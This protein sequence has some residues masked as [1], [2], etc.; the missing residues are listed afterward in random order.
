MNFKL[1]TIAGSLLLACAVSAHAS[2]N[3]TPIIETQV[4]GSGP[5]VILIPGLMSDARV[6][7]ETATQLES[8]Y[9]VHRIS[10]AGFGQTPLNTELRNSFSEPVSN[11]LHQYIEQNTG[12]NTAVVGHSLGAFLGYQ[13]ALQGNEQVS[14]A[15][16][17]DGVPFF[18]ALVTMTPGMTAEQAQPHA[19]QML[20][21]YQQLSVEMM[22]QQTQMG[23]DRQTQSSQGQE[24]IM[25]MAE[26]SDPKTVGRAM[27]E[28]MI[29]D[30]R[31]ELPHLQTPVLQMAAIG[32]LPASQHEM[33]LSQYQQQV[34][35]SNHVSLLEFNQAHHFVM[36]DQP[37][38]FMQATQN[39]MEEQCFGGNTHG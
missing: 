31:P 8:H 35:G 6:W 5:D 38:A 14:C 18:S 16:A 13:L 9:T 21:G 23:L 36:W 28:L 33:A 39:F 37:E 20:Q 3:A 12:S 24:L 29:T 15:V 1:K 19:E 30:L 7:Q 2:S 17:V 27:Y 22:V 26:G 4:T 25:S 32:A 11:A 10:I 34:S